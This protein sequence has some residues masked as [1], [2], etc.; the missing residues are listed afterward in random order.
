M[1]NDIFGP[2]SNF[3]KRFVPNYD[4]LVERVEACRQLGVRIVLTSGAFDIKHVGHD[5]YLE[6]GKRAAEGGILV[7][8]VDS[9]EK[10]T[11]RKGP[12]RP[13]VS[14]DERL[15]AVCHL[16]HVDLVTLKQKESPKWELIRRVRP[17][18]SSYYRRNI[19]YS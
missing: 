12:N 13:I 11:A 6:Q 3:D 5:R 16:R 1:A 15:E 14:Q 4:E 8:G 17:G 2:G 19:R 18:C 7:V 9:D 10:V